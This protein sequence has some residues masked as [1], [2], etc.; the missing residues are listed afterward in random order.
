[1]LNR[2]AASCSA[3]KVS[4]EVMY[5]TVNKK[6]SY[7]IF[8]CPSCKNLFSLS[9]KKKAVCPGCKSEELVRYNPNVKQNI[10]FYGQMLKKKMLKKKDY[11]DIVSYWKG[12]EESKCP[13]CGKK[14]LSWTMLA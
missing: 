2:Y 6:E 12:I 8:S 3:C 9:N 4:F 10:S 13:S 5:G 14:K 1:M 7:E 11:N